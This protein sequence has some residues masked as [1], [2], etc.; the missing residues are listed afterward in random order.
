MEASTVIMQRLQ[1]IALEDRLYKIFLDFFGPPEEGPA[2]YMSDA[3]DLLEFY[4]NHLANLS[5][6]EAFPLFVRRIE[7][8]GGA[9]DGGEAADP[10][11]ETEPSDEAIGIDGRIPRPKLMK[12]FQTV[13]S[14]RR[15][16][17]VL[18]MERGALAMIQ[19][20]QRSEEEAHQAA[21]ANAAAASAVSAS[22]STELPQNATQQQRTVSSVPLTAEAKYRLSFL[23][24]SG[25]A[26]EAD[27]L[28]AVDEDDLP[29]VQVELN[30]VEPTF[31]KGLIR[32][33]YI[34]YRAPLISDLLKTASAPQRAAI[35][36]RQKQNAA[37]SQGIKDTDSSL[38]KA[39]QSQMQL[40]RDR[41]INKARERRQLM[42]QQQHQQQQ[43]GSSSSTNL[44]G[45]MLPPLSANV[46]S[47]TAAAGGGGFKSPQTSMA[48]AVPD[49]EEEDYS[50]APNLLNTE[51]G[52]A[53]EDWT[54]SNKAKRKLPPW[55]QWMV[56]EDSS[57]FRGKNNNG[58]KQSSSSSSSIQEQRRALP[59]FAFR[60]QFLQHVREN[61]TTVLVGETGSGKT[62]QI[63]QYL[64]EAG[65]ASNGS[66]MICC[67]QPR[68]VAAEELAKRVAEEYGCPCGAEVGYTVRFKDNTS[69]LTKIKYM[70]DGMLLREALVDDTF[71]R[72]SVIILDEAHERSINTDVLFAVVKK[73]LLKRPS[74]KVVVTSATLDTE[75]FCSFFGAAAPF[76]I[77]GRTFPV[78][79][80][81]LEE[82]SEDYV[83]TAL[84]TVMMIHLQEAPGDILVFFTGQ[85]EI[86][87]A[88]EKLCGWME[89]L[90]KQPGLVIPELLVLPLTATLPEEVQA[91]VFEKTPEG[92]RKVVLATNVAETS[93]TIGNL[94]FVVDCG[95]CKQNVFDS[96]TGV[97][98]LKIVPISQAQADQ[99]AGRAGRIGPG[100]AYR[101]YTETQYLE[102]ME[103]ATV[104]E[105][106]RSN[107]F[108]VVLQLKAVGI[109]DLLSFD[110]M[111][112]PPQDTLVA[113]L[114][115]LRYL[116][117]LDDDG[118]LTRLGR[119]L[120]ALPIDPSQ[121]KTLLTAVD[122]GCAGPVL[123]IVSMLAV[124]KRGIFYRPREHIEL[125]DAKKRAFHQPEGDQ[126]TLMAIYNQ[127]V[128]NGMSEEWSR[129]NFVKQRLLLEAR[130]TRQQLQDMLT[131][132]NKVALAEDHP[133]DLV[134]VRKAITAGYFF[135]AARRTNGD[136]YVTLSDRREVSMHPSSSLRD[137][138]PKYVIFDELHLT[139]REFMREVMAIDPAWLVELAPTFYSLPKA[140]KLTKEQMAQ[141]IA[142]TL[143]AYESGA[144]WRI[145]RLRPPR[146]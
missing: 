19:A 118:L 15:A 72:Y 107:L 1:C 47:T 138:Q 94:F 2:S 101:L 13:R 136:L 140:G 83:E 110:F 114:Q 69:P 77:Q 51:L 30:D 141:R 11:S 124:Q 49:D 134:L 8:G 50:A 92:T 20:T 73:A 113:A 31:L 12:L 18:A 131:R 86:D 53:A 82:N 143:Q 40:N 105:I 45:A 133:K 56:R 63:P 103:L 48:A 33:P 70:T 9:E 36:E 28:D 106:Q 42:N 120:A 102:E 117:A 14:Y 3:K 144:S 121:G 39:A 116:E 130:D 7:G 16:N 68:R 91:K 60:D 29:Q 97:E 54:V 145:S 5:D 109:N 62:T 27:L 32:K 24:R 55:M 93:I 90:K 139:S 137:V 37:R 10:L 98:Q 6:D 21:I 64:A 52:G 4:D 43:R 17:L 111:D 88:G 74:L 95:F 84:R 58:G 99:R 23:V 38:K 132:N 46:S 59:I 41:Q 142:P 65:F 76:F 67:T 71:Q 80:F 85:E 104:P 44:R 25:L 146:K 115:K 125:A 127:W 75:K 81:Y 119:R 22:S 26:D 87:N 96:K 78:E 57:A 122:L 66:G 126:I 35:L 89:T 128:E 123:T 79:K 112:A 129:Q 108:N 61:S 135:Q 34:N 100:K